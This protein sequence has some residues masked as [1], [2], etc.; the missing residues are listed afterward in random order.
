MKIIIWDKSFYKEYK[1]NIFARKQH[2]GRRK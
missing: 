1:S 2:R